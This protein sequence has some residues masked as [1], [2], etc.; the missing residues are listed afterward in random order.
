[1][2]QEKSYLQAQLGGVLTLELGSD[3]WNPTNSPNDATVSALESYEDNGTIYILAGTADGLFRRELDGI[4]WDLDAGLG[5][6]HVK[7]LEMY[8]EKGDRY[9]LAGTADGIF[10]AKSGQS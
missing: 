3:S 1:M 5:D 10:S 8:T 7:A 6:R 9:L 4:S 2:F